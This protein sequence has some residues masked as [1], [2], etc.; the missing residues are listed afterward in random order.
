MRSE[1]NILNVNEE[2]PTSTRVIAVQMGVS[3]RKMC[4]FGFIL[5]YGNDSY[6]CVFKV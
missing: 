5:E 1:E 2:D 4:R 3:Q 6:L